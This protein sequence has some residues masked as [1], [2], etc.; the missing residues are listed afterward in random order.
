MK[1]RE[2]ILGAVVTLFVTVAGGVFV[3]YLTRDQQ[4]PLP[5]EKLVYNIEKSTVFKTESTELS[6][7]TV[8]AANLGDKTA[9]NVCLVIEYPEHISISDKVISLSTEPAGSYEDDS[10]AD[11]RIDLRFPTL[12]P[13]ENVTITTML[14]GVLIGKPRVVVRSENSE[15]VEGQFIRVI[16][17]ASYKDR[18][19]QNVISTLIPVAVIIQMFLVILLS[20]YFRSRL[21]RFLPTS[22]SVNNTGFLFIHKGLIEEA[23]ALFSREV[24]TRGAN[25]LVLA[26]YALALGLNG[27]IERADKML[28][29]AEWWARNKRERAVVAFNSAILTFSKEKVDEGREQLQRAF[30]IDREAI[31]RYCELSIFIKEAEKNHREIRS[32]IQNKGRV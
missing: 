15:G 2:F 18:G 8:R 21:M 11:N 23:E 6:F 7:V 1:W 14:N 9:H 19:T 4:P 12:I 16:P 32:L 30:S 20:P 26:N 3:Y 17:A 13:N 22:S 25:A 5:K 24:E 27:K 31:T 29:A 28:T 10:K